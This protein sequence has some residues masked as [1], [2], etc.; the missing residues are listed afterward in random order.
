MKKTR[1]AG[2]V[3][4]LIIYIGLSVIM[5]GASGFTLYN[6]LIIIISGIIIFVPLWKKYLK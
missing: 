3:G 2:V 4:L 6:L 1:I 5:I